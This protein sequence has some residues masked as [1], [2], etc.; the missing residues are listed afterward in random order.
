MTI[1]VFLGTLPLLPLQILWVNL[2]TD[3]FQF[4][5]WPWNRRK[6]STHALPVTRRTDFQPANEAGSALDWFADRDRVVGHRLFFLG[7]RSRRRSLAHGGVYRV[8]VAQMANAFACR[9]K[10]EFGYCTAPPPFS[11]VVK[12]GQRSRCRRRG[13]PSNPVG[14]VTVG[15]TFLLQMLVVYW[16]PLQK[17]FHTQSLTLFELSVCI[18]AE[19]VCVFSHRSKKILG[20]DCL[21]SRQCSRVRSGTNPPNVTWADVN[22]GTFAGKLPMVGF[23]EIAVRPVS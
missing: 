2:V 23:C 4:R 11:R 9:P 14:C 21:N 17:I 22:A 3:G 7:R 19:L 20:R 1:G 18:A 15:S 6:P 12:P 8:D 13:H 5:H 10:V 16:T